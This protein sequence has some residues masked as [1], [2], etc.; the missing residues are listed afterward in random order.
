DEVVGGLR[1]QGH[2][3]YK[4]R[5]SND[6]EDIYDKTRLTGRLVGECT[7]AE[8]SVE[9][10][11]STVSIIEEATANEPRKRV[12]HLLDDTPFTVGNET[13]IHY[14]IRTA[15]GENVAAGEGPRTYFVIE[16]DRIRALDPSFISLTHRSYLPETE[17]IR[18]TTAYRTDAIVELNP[19]YLSQPAPRVV[20]AMAQLTKALHPRAYRRALPGFDDRFD[21]EDDGDDGDRSEPANPPPPAPTVS[22]VV[23]PTGIGIV[24]VSNLSAE[25]FT[26][27][28]EFPGTGLSTAAGI[29]LTGVSI[30]R[31]PSGPQSFEISLRTERDLETIRT[32][33]NAV[34][35]L[36][37]FHLEAILLAKGSDGRDTVGDG[38][39]AKA[40]GPGEDQGLDITRFLVSDG[41]YAAVC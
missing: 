1:Q 40:G 20:I 15:G 8:G 21:L 13:F 12:L 16:Q 14:V 36:G 33:S 26:A 32:E 2:T 23:R 3:V 17:A 39:V 41:D 22:A 5:I 10:M 4:F 19:N 24:T 34:R 27:S 31:T 28:A 38:G 35:V 7:G 11:R 30:T 9:E 29:D 6:L 37:G 25:P 18:A